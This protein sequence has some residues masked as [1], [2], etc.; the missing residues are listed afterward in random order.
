MMRGGRGMRR[1]M[2][3]MGMDMSNIPDV[4]EVVIRTETKDLIITD[5][6]VDQMETKENVIFMIT[7]NGFEEREPETP[8]YS[9]DDIEMICMRTNVSRDEAI[10]A[11]A[12]ANGELATALLRLQTG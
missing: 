10:A 5:A 7:T 11:L 3:K 4:L 8:T 6:K 2:D 1:A 12:D 9:E